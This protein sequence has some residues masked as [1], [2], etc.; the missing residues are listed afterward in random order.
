MRK[1]SWL[2]LL[3]LALVLAL[4]AVACAGESADTTEAPAATEAPT[5]TEAPA[6]TAAPETTTTTEAPAETEP[7]AEALSLLVWA[8]ANRAPVFEAIAPAF[9]EAT[10]VNIEVQIVDFG[11]IR[12]QVQVAGPAGEGP[13]VFVG[14][15]DWTGELAANGVVRPITLGPNEGDFFQVGIDGFSYE[16]NLYAVPMATEAIA[17]YVNLD[18]VPEPPASIEEIA[19]LCPTLEGIE[20]CIG[21][22]GGG[23]GGDLY[24]NIWLITAQGG[25]IFGYD[26]ASG[27]DTT[28]VGLDSE[29][30]IAG[31]EV[32]AQLTADGI[33]A[34]TNYDTAKNLFL[35]GKQPFWV[36]GPWERGTLNDS[37]LN[38]TVVKLPTING[39][40]PAPFVGVQGVFLSAFAPNA[41]VA[42]SFLADYVA[43]TDVQR[44]LY[45]ADPRNPATQSVLDQL[46]D[47]VVVATFTLSGADGI[48]MP[49]VPEMGSVWG[50]GGDNL[51]ALRNGD[52]D[53]TT[54]MTTAADQVRELLGN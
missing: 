49:N 44:A 22:P 31:A 2:R 6:T 23:D 32:I 53:A 37:D 35:E 3:A 13:D 54:A 42:Q 25:Y 4:T 12:E 14:A 34:S 10:G 26:A 45:D 24:H 19:E 41:V 17:M 29:G 43:T 16:G 15:H 36:T 5:A 48:P 11:D 40:T 38:W 33:M 28:D 39:S 52:V 20:N 50:A 7:P 1:H 9:E 27:Y 46:A 30:A 51:L 21:V 18:L 8:D 47:D